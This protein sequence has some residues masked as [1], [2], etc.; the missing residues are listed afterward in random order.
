MRYFFILFVFLFSSC[1]WF[2]KERVVYIDR[3]IP[4]QILCHRT[5]KPDFSIT[6]TEDI[7]DLALELGINIDKLKLYAKNLETE[8]AC[9]YDSNEILKEEKDNKNE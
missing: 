7:S 4:I 3:P 9:I 5:V 1:S 2:V 6:E 8:I